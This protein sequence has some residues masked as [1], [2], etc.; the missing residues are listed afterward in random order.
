MSLPSYAFFYKNNEI[1]EKIF[2][3]CGWFYDGMDSVKKTIKDMIFYDKTEK[4]IPYDFDY[5]IIYEEKLSYNE[6]FILIEEVKNTINKEN[7]RNYEVNFDKLKV[8]VLN[9]RMPEISW[10]D[11]IGIQQLTGPTGKIFKMKKGE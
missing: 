5:V 7:V 2:I 9:R 3:N 6:F 1:I 8:P 10:K 11:V 4:E